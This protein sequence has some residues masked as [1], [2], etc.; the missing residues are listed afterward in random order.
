MN[1]GDLKDKLQKSL[2]QKNIKNLIL[3]LLVTIMCYLS[4]SYFTNVN[5]ISK[6]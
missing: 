4:L 6:I 5:N 1:I 3:I 2:R